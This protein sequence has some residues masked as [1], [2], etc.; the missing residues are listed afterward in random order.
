VSFTVEV[1]T[2]DAEVV[3]ESVA[4]AALDLVFIDSDHS[5]SMTKSHIA[6]LAHSLGKLFRDPEI[7][8]AG[9]VCRP[10]LEFPAIGGP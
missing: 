2:G 3:A 8:E 1:M 7:S 10:V 4:D 6:A 9:V 5:Y